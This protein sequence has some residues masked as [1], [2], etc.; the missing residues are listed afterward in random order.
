MGESNRLSRDNSPSIL[1]EVLD[2]DKIDTL[3]V[4]EAELSE[5]SYA[6]KPYDFFERLNIDA[7]AAHSL[8]KKEF[9]SATIHEITIMPVPVDFTLWVNDHMSS[10]NKYELKV[11]ESMAIERPCS[12]F[13]YSN[14]ADPAASEDIRIHVSGK[15]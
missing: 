9:L 7:T 15:W 12:R 3:R 8:T 6:L 5:I 10:Q 2:L 11:N 1:S 14:A 4:I 13:Y